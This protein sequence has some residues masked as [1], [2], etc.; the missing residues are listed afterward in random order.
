VNSE[1][2][3]DKGTP[4][5]NKDAIKKLVKQYKKIKKYHKSNLYQIKQLDDE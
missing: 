4:R 5:V 3:E 1:G 2:K